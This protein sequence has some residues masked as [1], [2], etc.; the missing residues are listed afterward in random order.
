MRR[1]PLPSLFACLCLGASVADAQVEFKR[2]ADAIR[3]SIAGEWLGDYRITGGAKPFLAPLR[4]PGGVPVTRDVD[5]VANASDHPHHT[6]L[7]Y[8]HGAVNGRDFWRDVPGTGRA[9]LAEVL[10]V[11]PGAT[12]GTI[13]TRQTL[14]DADGK[15]VATDERTLRVYGRTDR[16]VLD[17][18]ITWIAS[19]GPLHLGATKEGAFGVRVAD[20]M[21]ADGPGGGP[22]KLVNDAGLAN[23]DVVRHR[24]RWVAFSGPVGDAVFGLAVL[25]HPKN[26]HHPTWWLARE[27]GLIAANPFGGHELADAPEAD[28]ELRVAPGERVTFRYRVIVHRGPTADA[29]IE[30]EWEQFAATAPVSD[31]TL[32][33]RGV[34]KA[35]DAAAGAQR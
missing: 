29:G 9:A 20:S 11:S 34:G 12:V 3:V 7:W 13:R 5:P 26:P 25:D 28:C 19:H 1:L 35:G 22:G 18:E 17:Y 31:A 27:Y 32:A 24:A 16:R 2:E 14:L 33:A 10:E 21:R 8:A 30:A 23:G 15:T 4:A 6:S